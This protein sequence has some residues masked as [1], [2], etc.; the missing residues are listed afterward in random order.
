MHIARGEAYELRQLIVRS[1]KKGFMEEK[2]KEF[3]EEKITS[4]IKGING[5]IRFLRAKNEPINQV[6]N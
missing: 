5:Y 4:L 1:Q 3:L 6:T 2:S